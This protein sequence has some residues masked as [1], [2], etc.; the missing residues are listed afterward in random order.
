MSQGPEHLVGHGVR[1]VLVD[2]TDEI[3]LLVRHALKRIGIEVVGEA[4]DGAE[5]VRVVTEQ[6]PDLVILD[7]AMP[8]MDGLEALPLI[9]AAHPGV[10]IVM[11]SGFQVSLLG[12]VALERGADAFVEKGRLDHLVRAVLEVCP[13]TPA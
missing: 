7:I 13:P 9:R 12:D 1:A 10:R 5:G 11:L 4:G 6:L 2:D 3:R 8:V